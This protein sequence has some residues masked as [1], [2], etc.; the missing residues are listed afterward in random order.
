VLRRGGRIALTAI[1]RKPGLSRAVRRRIVEAEPRAVGTR[2]PY[3]DLLAD[4]GFGD[5][6]QRDAT[7]EYLETSRRWL[8]AT[9]P[10][11]DEVA[12]VDGEAAVAQKLL[13][14][15]QSIQAI[16]AGW[17]YRRIYWARVLD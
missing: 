5:V 8:A 15:R 9:E 17:L 16:E 2:K 13:D 11:R 12:A 7:A 3:P 14:W 6:G 1:E 4:A 10:V